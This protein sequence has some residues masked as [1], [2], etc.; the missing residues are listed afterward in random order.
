MKN[1]LETRVGLFFVLAALA[2]VLMLEVSNNSGFFGKTYV[3]YADFNNV[4]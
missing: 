1:R 2:A 4:N 3:L